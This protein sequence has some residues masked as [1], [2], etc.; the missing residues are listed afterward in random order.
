MSKP[1]DQS[2]KEAIMNYKVKEIIEY[3]ESDET[4][5]QCVTTFDKL[6][7]EGY[8]CKID[9]LIILIKR[10]IDRQKTDDVIDKASV[11]KATKSA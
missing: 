9:T 5:E 3:W 4:L 11:L 6:K 7:S 2:I 10:Y 1:V 8:T